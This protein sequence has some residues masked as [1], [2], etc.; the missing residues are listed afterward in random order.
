MSRPGVRPTYSVPFFIISFLTTSYTGASSNFTRKSMEF[1]CGGFHLYTRVHV[2]PR[3]ST[4]G[5]TGDSRGVKIRPSVSYSNSVSRI[6][7]I[8]SSIAAPSPARNI[9][10][11]TRNVVSDA[12]ENSLA[13]SSTNCLAHPRRDRV[14]FFLISS[15]VVNSGRDR[16]SRPL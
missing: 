4:C 9:F 5:A 15:S 10:V 12:L 3:V 1:W 6:V 8:A 14:G 2:F 16:V 7:L 13:V 11:S